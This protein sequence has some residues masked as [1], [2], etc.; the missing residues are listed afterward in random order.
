[1]FPSAWPNWTDPWLNPYRM[2]KLSVSTLS[3]LKANQPVAALVE[4]V[5][6]VVTRFNDTEV[7]VLTLFPVPGYDPKR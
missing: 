3:E 4:D 2:R 6:L 7:S 5:D 1:M